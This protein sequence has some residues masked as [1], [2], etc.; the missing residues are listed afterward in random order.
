MQSRFLV[1]T[2]HTDTYRCRYTAY[3]SAYSHGDT[4]VVITYES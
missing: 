2:A 3:G 1:G 4:R